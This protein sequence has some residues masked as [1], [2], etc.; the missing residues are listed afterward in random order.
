MSAPRFFVHFAADDV[1]HAHDIVIP[2]HGVPVTVVLHQAPDGA[3]V[4]GSAEIAP[5]EPE[6]D[7]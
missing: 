5:S 7:E 3:R 2:K 4:Y 1:Q 6:P